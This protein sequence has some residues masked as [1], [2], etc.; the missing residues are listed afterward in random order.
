[1]WTDHPLLSRYVQ[2]AKGDDRQGRQRGPSRIFHRP[3]P[4]LLLTLGRP[5]W[6]GTRVE[7]FLVCIGS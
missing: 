3:V 1:M 6:D 2:N 7:E 5:L 4:D